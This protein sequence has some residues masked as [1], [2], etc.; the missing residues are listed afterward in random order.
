[1]ERDLR[2]RWPFLPLIQHNW[3]LP[4]PSLP[5][6]LALALLITQ[7]AAAADPASVEAAKIHG[8]EIIE[9]KNVLTGLNFKE[10]KNLTPED[11]HQIR[12]LESL[13]SLSF[14]AGLDD[15]ALKILA[16]MPSLESF[17][18]NGA[19][20]SDEGAAALALFPSLR[21]LTFFHP[22]KAFQGTGLSALAAL[23]NF[24]SFSVGGS[25]TFSDPG[26][27]AVAG[28]PHLK[29]LRVWH[30]G[31]TI[32]GVK[33]WRALKE[34]KSLLLGQSLPMKPPALLDDNTVAVLAEF[35]SLESLTLQEARLSLAALARLKQLPN[36]KRLTLDNIDIPESDI[37]LLKQELPN[38]VIQW[39][40]PSEGAQRRIVA[41]FGPAPSGP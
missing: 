39:T 37:A 17:T 31:G 2:A 23:P 30:T 41:L 19:T 14:G 29:A 9:T 10:P 36:L 11:Y 35:S 38:A 33:T 28:L 5:L 27:T 4:C 22:G 16:G 24:E 26:M 8:A 13:K 21:N 20:L 40:A 6:A 12:R 32:E 34:L 7:R 18:T 15:A 3:V 25:T 1:M